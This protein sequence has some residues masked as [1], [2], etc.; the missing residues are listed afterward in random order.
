MRK[1]ICFVLFIFLV[2]SGFNCSSSSLNIIKLNLHP[3]KDT[4]INIMSF[5]E[6]KNRL[7]AKGIKWRGTITDLI[8]RDKGLYTSFNEEDYDNLRQSLVQSF[9]KSDVFKAVY[10]IQEEDELLNGICL[11]I[12]FDESGINQTSLVLF[13]F[14]NA[15]VWTEIAGDSVLKK[16]EIKAVGR[17]SWSPGAAKNDAITKFIREIGDLISIQSQ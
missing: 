4:V 13:C 2:T 14:L 5:S 6:A 17:S 11:Y 8:D 16:A 12:A 1:V 15:F 9:K 10:D 7:A 3:Q